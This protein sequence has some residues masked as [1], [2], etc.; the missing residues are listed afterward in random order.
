M[1]SVFSWN[2]SAAEHENKGEEAKEAVRF[3]KELVPLSV[4]VSWSDGGHQM[5][6]DPIG[7]RL[8]SRVRQNK[9]EFIEYTARE[10]GAGQPFYWVFLIVYLTVKA[11]LVTLMLLLMYIEEIF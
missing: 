9:G 11:K 6:G 7:W 3:L 4:G 5:W 1:A 10:Q 8:A 2:M